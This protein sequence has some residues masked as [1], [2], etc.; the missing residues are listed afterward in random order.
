[1]VLTVRCTP[2]LAVLPDKVT[3]WVAPV[4]LAVTAA[5]L[6]LFVICFSVKQNL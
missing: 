1:M 4:S 2:K 5:T 3:V 6:L